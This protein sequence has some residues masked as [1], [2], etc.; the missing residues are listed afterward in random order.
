MKWNCPLHPMQR[1]ALKIYMYAGSD[2]PS[3]TKVDLAAAHKRRC[4]VQKHLNYTNKYG[5]MP[6]PWSR[7]SA[8]YRL[9]EP[10]IGSW[11]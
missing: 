2:F 6:R 4:E 11:G 10:S 9:M 5:Y 3:P 8:S 7:A 1:D